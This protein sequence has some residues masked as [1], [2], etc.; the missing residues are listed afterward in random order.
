MKSKYTEIPETIPVDMLSDNAY[1]KKEEEIR[2]DFTDEQ[3]NDLE[4]ELFDIAARQAERNRISKI[5]TDLMNGSSELE[6]TKEA[7]R[8]IHI[9]HIG[10]IGLKQ[11]K[12]DFPK[13]LAKIVDGYEIRV[14]S[15]YGF[16]HQDVERMAFYNNKG[17]YI[18]DRPLS[19]AEK[20]TKFNLSKAL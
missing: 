1:L 9:G 5:V 17:E 10:E 6:A 2:Y 18:H 14:S 16:D 20:Q 15:V 19:A 11:L 7:I 12:K 3:I 4:H 13:Q 8:N